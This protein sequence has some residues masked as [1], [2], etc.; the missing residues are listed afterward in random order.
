M[1]APAKAKSSAVALSIADLEKNIDIDGDGQMDPEEKEILDLLRSMDVD[2]DGT[3]GLREL[4]NLGNQMNQA[5]RDANRMRKMIY[6]VFFLSI[7]FCGVMFCVSMAAV[8]AAKD[9]KPSESGT[10]ETVPDVNGDTKLVAIDTASEG[11]AITEIYTLD[12]ASLKSIEDIGYRLGNIYYNFHVI[13]FEQL[14]TA[15]TLT[16]TLSLYGGDSIVS[17]SEETLLI[18]I[19]T[20]QEIDLADAES[21]RKHR[22][23]QLLAANGGRS[24]LAEDMFDGKI[25]VKGTKAAK[26]GNMDEMMALMAGVPPFAM[27]EMYPEN[28]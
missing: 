6:G 27:D 21:K 15:D 24:L 18:R 13:G 16:V 8:E 2:G 7:L 3:I 11:V 12:L 4:V 9:S 14:I 23:R 5:S 28:Y 22:H 19:A 25:T 26:E 1:A 17:N 10:L 20:G